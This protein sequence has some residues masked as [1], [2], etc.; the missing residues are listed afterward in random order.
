[1]L[2]NGPLRIEIFHVPGAEPLP[3]QR[4]VPDTDLLTHGNKHV[5]FA[6]QDVRAF[7]DELRRRGADIVWVREMPQ[8]SSLFIRDNS[9]NLIEFVQESPS[10]AGGAANLRDPSIASRG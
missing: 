8:G 4:R 7:A 3:A 2:K 10:A 5:A 6:V 1:M 9:G